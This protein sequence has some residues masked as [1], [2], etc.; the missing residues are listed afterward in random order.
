MVLHCIA[1]VVENRLYAECNTVT[2]S[3]SH[4]AG[5]RQD[6]KH[7]ISLSSGKNNK[8]SNMLGNNTL[9]SLNK[10]IDEATLICHRLNQSKEHIDL[11]LVDVKIWKQ[12]PRVDKK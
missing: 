6:T 10:T 5:T 11:K 9:D 12:L 3:V 7:N 4:W 8:K 2:K 1:R